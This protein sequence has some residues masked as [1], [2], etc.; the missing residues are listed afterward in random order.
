[1]NIF[2]SY[3]NMVSTEGLCLFKLVKKLLQADAITKPH[4][5]SSFKFIPTN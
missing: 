4:K 1:M 2:D 3:W 5:Q